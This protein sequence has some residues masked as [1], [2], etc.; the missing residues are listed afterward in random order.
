MSKSFSYAAQF[1]RT[2]ANKARRAARRSRP[3][4]IAQQA[5]ADLRK[6]RREARRLE[7]MEKNV[8]RRNQAG[9]AK[10]QAE[11]AAALPNSSHALAAAFN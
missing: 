4:S 2:K 7:R 5:A 11:R 6:A 1:E 9:V 3:L 10:L 8:V